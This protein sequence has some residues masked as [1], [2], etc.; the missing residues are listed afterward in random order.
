MYCFACGYRE[1]AE[2]VRCKLQ[3]PRCGRIN[4]GCCEGAPATC[5]K[6]DSNSRKDRDVDIQT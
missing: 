2:E 1:D 3:C 6:D 5:K 4:E